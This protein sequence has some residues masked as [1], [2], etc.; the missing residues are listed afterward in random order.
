[1]VIISYGTIKDFFDNHTDAKDALNN[2]YRIVSKADWSSYHDLKQ[3]FNSADAV[4]NDRFVFNIR[5][6][7]YRLVAMIFFN[8]RTV[9]V[10]FVGTHKEY[11]KVDCSKI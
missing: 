7:N 8:V 11:E 3:M 9:Y 6:N 2:W 5:G 10:R 4:G 1:M